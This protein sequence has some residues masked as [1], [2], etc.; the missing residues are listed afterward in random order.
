MFFLAFSAQT[1]WDDGY[2]LNFNSVVTC[3][4]P[5]CYALFEQDVN[6]NESETIKKALPNIYKIFRKK[7]LFS[8]GNFIYWFI[9]G[10]IQSVIIFYVCLYTTDLEAIRSDGFVNGLWG[11]SVLAYSCTFAVIMLE[12]F[13]ET[14]NYTVVVHFFYWILAIFLY[15]PIF[16]YVWNVFS[17]PVQ[18]YAND[19]FI[20]GKFWLIVIVTMGICGGAKYVFYTSK[21]LFSPDEVDKLQI[22]RFFLK[23][24]YKHKQNEIQKKIEI[25]KKHS[26]N[27]SKN[28]QEIEMDNLAKDS[29]GPDLIAYEP[30]SSEKRNTSNYK[31]FHNHN[32]HQ[33]K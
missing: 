33:H 19:F 7:D 14:S 15:F 26:K 20:Y 13:I 28:G 31:F 24:E 32:N 25:I 22:F 3:F 30:Q 18:Y 21:K 27:A 17:S 16:V 5:A 11:F 9:K 29:E 10:L 2:L 1:F 23:K 8:Y 6:P 12:L 4:A